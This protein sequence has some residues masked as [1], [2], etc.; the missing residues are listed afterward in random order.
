MA[1]RRE[2]PTAAPTRNGRRAALPPVRPRPA[3]IAPTARKP[4]CCDGRRRTAVPGRAGAGARP[5]AAS[6][7]LPASFGRGTVARDRTEEATA[8]PNRANEAGTW[9]PTLAAGRAT[10]TM[11]SRPTSESTKAKRA[12]RT[13]EPSP[14]AEGR[15]PTGSVMRPAGASPKPGRGTCSWSDW[16]P[17]RRRASPNLGSSGYV[18]H[19]SDGTRSRLLV[20]A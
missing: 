1:E 13:G 3:P 10:S 6:N 20:C 18:F 12:P 4:R 9:R 15:P 2:A 14:L 7:P 5:G 11:T 17:E 16:F 8:D 19:S